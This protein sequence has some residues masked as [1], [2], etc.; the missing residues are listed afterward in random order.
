MPTFQSVV[1]TDR[2]ATP[3]NMTFNPADR[4][5]QTGVV[6]VAHS[7]DGSILA[8][9]KFSIS[10]RRVNGKS[11][12]RILFYAPVVQTEVINGISSPK[13]VR[14]SYVDCTFTFPNSTSEQ[15]RNDVVGM[16]QSAFGN[17]KTLVHDTIV[18]DESIF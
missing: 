1:L 3:V 7:V 8:R 14:E 4:N 2:T 13:V 16:F 15:E 17:T 11:K 9:K 10:K 5:V 6:T 18:K 12:T